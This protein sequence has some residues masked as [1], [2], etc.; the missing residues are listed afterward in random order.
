[1]IVSTFVWFINPKLIVVTEYFVVSVSRNKEPLFNF[2]YHLIC[3]AGYAK[4]EQVNEALSVASTVEFSGPCRIFTATIENYFKVSYQ[5]KQ[6][7]TIPGHSTPA[8]WLLVH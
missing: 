4:A 8:C 5:C 7:L 2:L 3:G 6:K 1:M